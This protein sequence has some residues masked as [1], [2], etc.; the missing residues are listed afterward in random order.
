MDIVQPPGIGMPPIVDMDAPQTI[1]TTVLAAKR[2][3]DTPKKVWWE[4]RSKAIRCEI[5]S[6]VVASQQ[7]RLL[8]AL[9]ILVVT[10]KPGA[11]SLISP[12]GCPVQPLVYA[13]K[14][15]QSARKGG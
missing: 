1:V 13:P 4:V 3:A 6:A 2:S 15:I 8:S 9:F 12:Q 5:L 11:I 14:A 7:P 10:A